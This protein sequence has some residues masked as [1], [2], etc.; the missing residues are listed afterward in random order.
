MCTYMYTSPAIV[1]Q[2]PETNEHVPSNRKLT[3]AQ[4]NRT[5]RS[6]ILRNPFHPLKPAKKSIHIWLVR[7]TDGPTDPI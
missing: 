7:P 5:G 6:P 2:K 1:P 4:R 3:A